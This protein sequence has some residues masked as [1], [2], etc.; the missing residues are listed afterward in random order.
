LKRGVTILPVQ[1]GY[2]G[3]HKSML[4]CA[5]RSNEVSKLNKIIKQYDDNPFIII[6]EAGE[7]VGEGFKLTEG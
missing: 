6:S 5:V 3:H 2:T 1:G 4:I 7:I